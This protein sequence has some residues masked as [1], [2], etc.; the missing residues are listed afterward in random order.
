[1][2]PLYP[3]PRPGKAAARA[4]S[5]GYGGKW[6]TRFTRRGGAK[7]VRAVGT[8][9]E[10]PPFLTAGHCVG[11]V[12]RAPIGVFSRTPGAR[13]LCAPS[14][15]ERSCRRHRESPYHADAT[16]SPPTGF[17]VTSGSA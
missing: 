15:T 4:L 14:A 2:H 3:G 7:A 17:G 16:E 12:T 6:A 13:G 9:L 11:R 1:M 10:E 8:S 5:L